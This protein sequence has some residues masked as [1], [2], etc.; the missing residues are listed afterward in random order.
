MSLN[1]EKWLYISILVILWTAYFLYRSINGLHLISDE[2]FYFSQDIL[3]EKKRILFLSFV[4]SFSN[5]QT[6][7]LSISFINLFAILISYIYLSKINFNNYRT[8]FF[9]L[10]YFTA[11]A[12]YVFRDSIILMLIILI[13][14][15]IFNQ[16]IITNQRFYKK[17]SFISFILLVSMLY[18]STRTKDDENR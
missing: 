4:Q 5:V 14:Y 15:I 18:L 13:F 17:L 1:K 16:K 11:V 7:Q 9:Q 12:S 2:N 10:I 6:A 3:F 8:T